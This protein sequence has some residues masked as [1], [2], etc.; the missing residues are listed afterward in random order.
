MRVGRMQEFRGGLEVNGGACRLVGCVIYGEAM[1]V[2]DEAGAVVPSRG[3]AW[4]FW[5]KLGWISFGGPAG[6]IALMH[7]E[8]VEEKKWVGEGAFLH[9]LN[10]CMLLPGPEAQQL[11]TYLGW[12]L[13]GIRG[14]LVA[15]ILFVLPAAML[16]YFLSWLYVWGGEVAWVGGFFHGLAP[17]VI[18]L[19]VAAVMRMG[20]KALRTVEA[21]VLAL[22]AWV[23]IG[24]LGIS[25]VWILLVAMAVGWWRGKGGVNG[26]KGGQVCED[27]EGRR[28]LPSWRR[29]VA[30]LMTGL[31]L[32]WLPVGLAGW[33][34]GWE[35]TL[36]RMGCFFSKTAVITFGGAYAVLPY[37]GQVAVEKYGWLSEMQMMAGLGLAEST[38]GPLI[39]VLPYVGFL[40]GWQ[41]S[42]GMEPWL[43]AT[44]GAAITIWVTFVPCFLWIFLGAPYVERLR[45]VSRVAGA[46][47]AV[48]AA[49]VGV[50]FHLMVWFSWHAVGGDRGVLRWE[51]LGLAVLAWYL[52][53]VR[54]FPVFKVMLGCGA[55]GSIQAAWC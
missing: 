11:A 47:G 54:R 50:I 23:G 46:M 21:W 51:V 4:R 9:A 27:G 7:R 43:A 17:G 20:K 15:G 18:A 31:G 33:L 16:L 39:M 35:S 3:E 24:W 37:V 13:H 32:W 2:A 22:G 41:Q 5:W 34:A 52:L 10:F 12:R 45:G 38:P 36:C 19:M 55:I 28:P 40:G 44:L 48:T 14:G 8:L 53:E 29:N 30:V 1:D 25:F 49:V 6:Q 42:G 26:V